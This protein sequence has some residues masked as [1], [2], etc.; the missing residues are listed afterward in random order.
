MTNLRTDGG[1]LAFT[2]VGKILTGKQ[3]DI[4]N[5]SASALLL[6]KWSFDDQVYSLMTKSG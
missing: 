5:I 3:F 6:I 4:A 2:A 1:L